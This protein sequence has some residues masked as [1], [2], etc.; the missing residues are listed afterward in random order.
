MKYFESPI[1]KRPLLK[2]KA[3]EVFENKVLGIDGTWG[4]SNPFLVDDKEP[5]ELPKA[6]KQNKKQPKT[7]RIYNHDEMYLGREFKSFNE[8][9]DVLGWK[10]TKSGQNSRK[11]QEKEI[12]Q[13]CKLEKIQ[14]SNRL[15][16]T[17]VYDVMKPKTD[18]RMHVDT[19]MINHAVQKQVLLVLAN[20]FIQRKRKGHMYWNQSFMFSTGQ[21][22]EYVGLVNSNFRKIRNNIDRYS[23]E[24]KCDVHHVSDIVN[25]INTNAKNVIKSALDQLNGR[26]LTYREGISISFEKPFDND[27]NY[28]YVQDE[29]A[30][31][32]QISFIKVLCERTV[33]NYY[34]LSEVK[35]IFSPT[36][37]T[38]K[39]KLNAFYYDV[40]KL[41]RQLC[42]AEDNDGNYLFDS[43]IQKLEDMDYYYS[44]YKITTFAPI[45]EEF[46]NSTL[47][48]NE[49]KAISTLFDYD[50]YARY[51]TT[52]GNTQ[53][54]NDMN[55]D[56]T[57][58]L[59]KDRRYKNNYGHYSYR[60]DMS[61][62]IIEKIANDSI[63]VK[64]KLTNED[65][66]INQLNE[67]QNDIK[68][69]KP[70]LQIKH[71]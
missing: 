59:A 27:G 25:S 45:L 61:D 1:H 51:L 5:L 28:M 52:L 67:Y 14:G 47:T 8:V 68:K 53:Q 31:D 36:K 55:H 9:T 43:D 17:E 18:K 16:I 12:A 19:T 46:E 64:Y 62:T 48:N 70:Q 23:R 34:G 30:T 15:V 60:K 63:H 57:I 22:I 21:M 32:N 71:L 41:A 56:K 44:S 42:V 40:V 29:F 33:L 66:V 11:A 50:D 65:K 3:K 6:V 2:N 37:N 49:K 4:E 39:L 38:Q 13:Y 10:R 54:V 26:Y 58:K 7:T 24:N 35:D 20:E 69:D